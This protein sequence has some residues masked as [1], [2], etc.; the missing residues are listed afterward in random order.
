MVGLNMEIL[1]ESKTFDTFML[2]KGNPSN[3]E[4]LWTHKIYAYVQFNNY[5]YMLILV[6]FMG[7]NSLLK[8]IF[9]I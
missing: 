3:V 2:M 1:E 6:V 9:V 5:I 4:Y 8:K 7:Q